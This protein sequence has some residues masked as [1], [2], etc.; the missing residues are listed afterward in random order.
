M[1]VEALE[2]LASELVGDGELPNLYFVSDHEGIILIS[3][4]FDIAH[5]AWQELPYDKESSLEDRLSGVICSTSPRDDSDELE[6]WDDSINSLKWIKKQTKKLEAL[7][8][9]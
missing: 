7:R 4:D 6:T 2:R 9:G 5:E 8:R 1:R 3:Q